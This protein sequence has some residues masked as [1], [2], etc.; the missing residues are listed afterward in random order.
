M[1]NIISIFTVLITLNVLAQPAGT[2]DPTFG[3]GGKVVTSI[4]PG[5]DKAY[6]V[7][8]Q[9]DGRIIVAGHSSSTITGKDFAVIR[10]NS[11]GSLDNTFGNNGIAT[12]DLQTG[13]D[14]VA[15][16]IALQADGKIVLAGYSDNGSNK[17][18]ALVR[19]NNDGSLDNTFGNNGIVLT[20]FE[21]SQLDEIKVVKVHPLTGN[22]IVGGS[23]VISTYI[24][25][26]VIARYLY[27]GTLDYS[28]NQTGIKT[29][30]IKSGDN[31][32]IFA[33][34]DL[35]VETNGKISA[36]GWERELTP[37]IHNR[38]WA[39]RI[40]SNG[41]MDNS[42]SQDGVVSYDDGSTAAYGFLL[43]NN[44]DFILC[45]S[46]DYAG[47]SYLKT[48]K[49]NNNGS[50]PNISTSYSGYSLSG[51]HT[52]R[53][54]IEDVNGKY[55][56]IGSSGSSP[57]AQSFLIG[58]LKTNL[59]IDNTFTSTGFTTTSFGASLNE[60]F[61]VAIQTD[62][63]IVV[64]GYTGSNF[65]IARYLGNDTPEL[66]GF[67]L[68]SP[69]NLSVNQ[70]FSNVNFDWSDAY[71]VT[72]YEIDVDVSQSFSNPQTYTTLNSSFSVNN[73]LP[74]TQYYW[75]VRAS[76][77]TNWGSYS[78]AWSFTTNSLE[79]FNLVSPANSSIN[80][81]YSSLILNW[82][83]NVGALNYELQ[84]DTTQSFTTN[85][86]TYTTTNSTYTVTLMPSKTYYWKVR[87]SNGTNWGQWTTVWN[88]TTKAD[89][90]LSIPEV[91]FS[92]IKIYPNPTSNI[93]TFEANDLLLLNKPFK[94]LDITG[95]EI[96][97]GLINSNQ[98]TIELNGLST[99]TYLLQI[100]DYPQQAFKLLK[101]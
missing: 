65:A 31:S 81:G 60:A 88:F 69:I 75:R 24:G 21:N 1:K 2:L 40:L 63:K 74:N 101:E 14:D 28:F 8:I 10:Y 79:N 5:Q 97:Y 68:I 58:R 95:K 6:G 53:K 89:S 87:A 49:I 90:S 73:L 83:D 34:E 96:F 80:Q 56:M 71:A 12:T 18:A 66:N 3:N 37:G 51:H 59:L 20:D 7:A 27:D 38:Y 78:N 64:V 62:N 17:D 32:K 98:V 91:Y 94:L 99:G 44:K 22:I 52:A 93:V 26:P 57:S 19:Y 16:S 76:D 13:S 84:I 42:F 35:I 15:Y 67:Q 77:G 4:T 48:I 43:N 92:N 46:K 33:V 72:S 100:G 86:L 11:D 82:S 29:L 61:G 36:A 85:T 70:N 47:D 45:G 23:S 41:D 25:K 54:I 55:V 50:I 30:W 39:C 9:T